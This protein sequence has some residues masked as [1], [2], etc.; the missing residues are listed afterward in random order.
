MLMNLV[1]ASDAVLARMSGS[2]G[3]VI[4]SFHKLVRGCVGV[5]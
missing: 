1:A 4:P 3:M 5:L 2:P